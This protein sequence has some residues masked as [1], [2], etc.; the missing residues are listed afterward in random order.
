MSHSSWDYRRYAEDCLSLA[1]RANSEDKD[2]LLGMAE[3]WLN[4]ATEQLEQQSTTGQNAP[5]NQ[6]SQ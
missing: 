6:I 5:S 1:E 2:K 4:L 3:V